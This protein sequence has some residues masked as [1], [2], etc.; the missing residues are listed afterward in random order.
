MMQVNDFTKE[1]FVNYKDI[2]EKFDDEFMLTKKTADQDPC[3][4]DNYVYITS[5]GKPI[6]FYLKYTKKY[7]EGGRSLFSDSAGLKEEY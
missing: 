6:F 7:Q 1:N 4:C 5:T 3:T 2:V